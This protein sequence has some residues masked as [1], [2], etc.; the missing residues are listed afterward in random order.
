MYGMSALVVTNG[1]HADS[2]IISMVSVARVASG[3]DILFLEN[4]LISWMI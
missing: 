3:I 4:K 1:C 2:S